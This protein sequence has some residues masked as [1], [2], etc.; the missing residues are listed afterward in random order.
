M[1]NLRSDAVV[2]GAGPAGSIAARTLAKNGVD[3][4]VVEKRQEIGA[5][6]RC[7]EGIALRGL[8]RVGIKPDPR[9]AVNRITGAILYS[10]SG[11][12]L[13]VST[14]DTEGY[15]LERKIFEK[16]LAAEA[17]RSGAR[18]MVKTRAI[19][20][21]KDNGYVSG[22][23]AEYM[24]EEFDIKSKL[25]IAADGVDSKIAKSAGI[26]TMNKLTDYHSGFQ[27]EM[28]NLNLK[29]HDRLHIYFGRKSILTF[30]GLIH[31]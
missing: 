27:Y 4:I 25:V 10:P 16:Y 20:V 9:W 23:H 1:Q 11:R 6:K 28:A 21:I 8:T 3:V 15:I 22:I 26:D 18:Y 2:V 12:E 24:G 14:K 29:E 5:P 19:S 17:I 31:I 13:R 7:A 30:N